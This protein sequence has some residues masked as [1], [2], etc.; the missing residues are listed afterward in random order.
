MTATDCDCGGSMTVI[1]NTLD[2]REESRA[3]IKALL[4]KE[5]SETTA[6][7]ILAG[8]VLNICDLMDA[9]YDSNTR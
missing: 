3:L 4:K 8:I 6:V 1:K 9:V 7:L 2:I 5:I